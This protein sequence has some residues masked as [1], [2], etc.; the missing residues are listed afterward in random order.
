MNKSLILIATIAAV[1]FAA[2]IHFGIDA[3]VGYNALFL[4]EQLGAGVVTGSP[5]SKPSF[6]AAIGPTFAYDL[7]KQF[8]LGGSALFVYDLDRFDNAI[9]LGLGS[10]K[11]EH[12]ISQMSLG[13]QFAPIFHINK[14]FSVKFGYEWDM[15]FSGTAKTKRT[16][17]LGSA[18]NTATD[19]SDIVWAPAKASDVGSTELPVLSTHNLILGG[20]YQITPMVALT[21]QVKMGLT[22]SVP[23][24]NAS[25]DLDGGAGSKSNMTTNQLAIGVS[26]RM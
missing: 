12:T 21:L 25:G 20:A 16:T 14:F 17:T 13:L 4:G 9:D 22:G 2:P 18:V 15:P 26:F 6:G 5:E 24:Y 7:T 1:S 23:L 10:N 11:E 19:K 8:A 3:K